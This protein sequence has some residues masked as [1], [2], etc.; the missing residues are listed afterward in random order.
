MKLSRSSSVARA[1]KA[2][3]SSLVIMY[4]TSLSSHFLKALCGSGL[5]LRGFSATSWL[6]LVLSGGCAHTPTIVRPET[7]SPNEICLK[8]L[9]FDI[10]VKLHHGPYL[11]G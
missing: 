9:P 1:L 6:G 10:T 4:A 11:A 7:K 3:F 2:F 5:T 8:K